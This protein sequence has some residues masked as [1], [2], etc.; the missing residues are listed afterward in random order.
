MEELID[1]FINEKGIKYSNNAFLERTYRTILNRIK[2]RR[3]YPF[4]IYEVSSN[5]FISERTLHRRL[6][7][8]G[9]TYFKIKDDIR[10][11]Y[12]IYL[13]S[14]NKYT[15]K[16]ISEFLFFRSSSSFIVSFKRWYFCTPQ[17]WIYF[18]KATKNDD[19]S[20]RSNHKNNKQ[21]RAPPSNGGKLIY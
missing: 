15:T 10:K 2:K 14:L 7:E 9:S 8:Q 11:K 13:L 16:Q 4:N 19:I 21:Y 3:T 20:L 5:L 6:K 12:A 18:N 1:N 17:E